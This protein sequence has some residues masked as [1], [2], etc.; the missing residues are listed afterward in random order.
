M[1][2]IPYDMYTER[3]ERTDTVKRLGKV[4]QVV[5][6]V[7]ESAGPAVSIGRLC[8]IENRHDGSEAAAGTLEEA[9]YLS[10]FD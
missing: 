6:L 1:T 7:I 2:Y 10:A 9:W 8:T 5:G 4:T 3:I